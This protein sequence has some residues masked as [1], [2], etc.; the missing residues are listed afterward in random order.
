MVVL[1]SCGDNNNSKNFSIETNAK[2][3]EMT[4]GEP[5]KISIKNPKNLEINSVTYKIDDKTIE[6]PFPTKDLKLGSH[7]ITAVVNYNDVSDS[8]STKI[9]LLNNELPKIYT[10]KIINKYPHDITSHL[11]SI[12]N[13][14]DWN[15]RP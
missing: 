9:Y 7:K 11:W 13:T 14:S 4:L 15:F 8:I 1:V 5:L 10:Y 12:M 6:N 3:N 2:K